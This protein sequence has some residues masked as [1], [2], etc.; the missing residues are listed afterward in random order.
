MQNNGNNLH[1]NK[2]D[3]DYSGMGNGEWVILRS[4]TE[5]WGTENG[6]GRQ[7]ELTGNLTGGGDTSSDTR[8][9]SGQTSTEGNGEWRKRRYGRRG[10]GESSPESSIATTVTPTLIGERRADGRRRRKLNASPQRLIRIMSPFQRLRV[11]S[12]F[13][14]S[15]PSSTSQFRRSRRV[16]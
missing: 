8:T 14:S 2:R 15:K 13:I 1:C 7:R 11:L 6:E 16:L 12:I 3:L 5:E 9:A 4:I 10:E